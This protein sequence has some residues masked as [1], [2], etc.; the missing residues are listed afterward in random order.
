MEEGEAL[1]GDCAGGRVGAGAVDAEE[2]GE[3]GVDGV[4][5]PLVQATNKVIPTTR[6]AV[7][8]PRGLCIHINYAVSA[9]IDA[10]C[11]QKRRGALRL[12]EQFRCRSGLAGARSGDST[13]RRP[14][15]NGTAIGALLPAAK[16][17][18]AR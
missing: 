2:V 15:Y 4:D 9:A 17:G 16:R 12:L 13:A 18:G 7:K 11:P 1:L 6:I 5:A 14:S 8:D 3:S 10:T